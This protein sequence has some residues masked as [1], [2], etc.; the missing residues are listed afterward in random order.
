MYFW[1]EASERYPDD[2]ES[3]Y[4]I[5]NPNTFEEILSFKYEKYAIVENPVY[6]YIE[7]HLKY[8][9]LKDSELTYSLKEKAD[10]EEADIPEETD[11]LEIIW[12]DGDVCIQTKV[13]RSGIFLS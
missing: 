4:D 8:Y 12:P 9:C 1:E 2:V 5:I 13:N 6:D 3:S 7:L 11:E 10:L